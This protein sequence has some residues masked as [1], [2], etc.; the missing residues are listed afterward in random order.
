M[1]SPEAALIRAR[2]KAPLPGLVVLHLSDSDIECIK[3]LELCQNLQSLYADSNHIKDLEGIIELRK[4]WRIDLNGNL[5]QE[6][7]ALASYRALGFLYLE[8]NRIGFEDLVCLRDQHLLELRLAGNAGLLKGNSIDGYRKKVVALLPNVWILDSHFI[9]TAE[10]RQAIEEFDEFVVSL[11][12]QPRKSATRDRKFG[13]AT[14]VWVES[15]FAMEDTAELPPRASLIDTAHKS[16]NPND[17]PDLRRLYAIVSFHNAESATHNPHCHFAPSRQAPNSRLMPKIWLDEVLALPRQ[18][19]IEVILLLAVFIQFRF[20]MVLLSEA[21]TIRQLD[22]PNFPSEAIRDTVNLPPYALVALIAIARHVSLDTEQQMRE[23]LN[24]EV[25]TPE[26]VDESEFLKSIPTL[27][28]TLLSTTSGSVSPVNESDPQ[29]TTIRCRQAIKMLSNVASFPDPVT[30]ASKGTGKRG[31]IFR[32]L[33]PL[34]HAAESGP[35]SSVTQSGRDVVVQSVVES[36]HMTA[37]RSSI[38]G[39]GVDTAWK[40]NT[41]TQDCENLDDSVEATPSSPKEGPDTRQGI[42]S[43]NRA[44]PAGSAVRRKPKPGD[45][46]EV[47]A[48]QFVKIRFLSTD[49]FFVVGALPT[50]ECRSI[51]ISL[52]QMSRISNSVWRVNYLTKLQAEEIRA[53]LQRTGSDSSSMSNT[54]TGK[55]HRDSDGF[56]RHGAA[57]NQGSPNHFVTAQMLQDLG[58]ERDNST[59]QPSS[60]PSAIEVFS[61]NDTLDANYVLT[62][63]EHI[64]AQNYC[65]ASTFLQQ[66][67]PPRGLWSPMKQAAPYSVLGSHA[68]PLGNSLSLNELKTRRPR[69]QQQPASAPQP[70]QTDDWLEIR[71]AMQAQLGLADHDCRPST[72]SSP[73]ALDGGLQPR[74]GVSSFLTA[75]TD[76]EVSAEAPAM[77][78]A[79]VDRSRLKTPPPLG[80]Q[81]LAAARGWHQ[82]ATK[83]EFVVAASPSAPLLLRPEPAVGAPKL[84]L[85]VLPS[86]SQKSK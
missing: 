63:P 69:A 68:P 35:G 9:S 62:S 21:L 81:R 73:R 64:A 66:R 58:R 15:E 79:P 44:E 40:R 24:P 47:Y 60:Q 51:T 19:R 4:L 16:T 3:H 65:A 37:P 39:S 84:K 70:Q 43:L 36:K 49:G 56:H 30:M 33:V 46:V 78:Q 32:E 26:F 41:I 45:W 29:A 1:R 17:P 5:L 48:K 6:L 31:A 59:P 76:C 53:S 74:P 11:L 28:T 42:A 67:L 75:A 34:I 57:R 86:I 52:E 10:R 27:F 2:A 77:D 80:T 38:A 50:D 7:H 55:L 25:A 14:D 23:Q 72:G 20:P 71:R 85:V 8:R 12:K 22:S 13:S 54:R 83:T 82:V 18:T 61:S